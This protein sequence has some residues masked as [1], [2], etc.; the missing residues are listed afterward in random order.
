MCDF[1]LSRK[2]TRPLLGIEDCE[3]LQLIQRVQHPKVHIHTTVLEFLPRTK[4]EFLKRHIDVFT[5]VGTFKTTVKINTDPRVPNIMSPPRRYNFYIIE[6]LKGK[7][8][9]LEKN[10]VITKVTDEIPKF[11]SNLVIREKGNG[12]LR[13]CLDPEYLN[14]AIVRQ[15]YSIPSLDELAYKVKDKKVFTVLDLKDGF[16]HVP[17]DHDSSLLCAFSTPY[18]VYRFKKLPFGAFQQLKNSICQAPALRPYDSTKPMI[19]QADASQT[20]LGACLLQEGTLVSAV[21][22]KLTETEQ[23]YAQI[24]KEMLALW[25][26]AS[27][28][29][30][31][32]YGMRHVTFHTDHQP[33]VSICKK[34]LYQIT[35]NR[36]KRLRLKMLKF[37][38]QVQY[39]PGKY[40]Y[41]ADLLSRQYITDS[42]SDDPDMAEVV[43]EVTRHISIS[44]AVL[45]E[46]RAET[47]KDQGLQ[48]VI[49]Y[50][51]NGWPLHKRKA[52]PSSLQYWKV[53]KDLFTEQG[54]VV[55]DNKIIIPDN[56]RGKVLQQL[57]AAHLGSDKTK[58]R[59]RQIVYWPGI[60]ADI[61]R[62]TQGCRACERNSPNNMKE[63]LIPHEVPTLRYQKV[64]CDLLDHHNKMYLVVVDNFSKW[65]ELKELNNKSSKAVIGALREIFATHGI[66]EEIFGDNNPLNSYECKE[67]A[68][69]MGSTIVTSSPEYPRSNGLAERGVRTAK[70]IL[71]KSADSKSHYLDMVRDYNN[72][73]LCGTPFSPAQLLMSRMCR[74][75]VPT[76]RKSLE[77]KVIDPLPL[78]KRRQLLAKKYHD[79]RARRQP[80]TFT[81]GDKI[82]YRRGGKWH[83]GTIVHKHRTPRSYIIR[84]MR[85]RDLRRNTFHLKRSATATDHIDRQETLNYNIP[86]P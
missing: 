31:F 54:L 78:L 53:Q 42:V 51:K 63:P 24:E 65:L 5:G 69:S 1:L 46:C 15:K 2:H 82:A 22:R 30:K 34:P 72:T 61:E 48:S 41:L 60:T 19:V 20:G 40:M 47:A 29:E 70:Q 44:N 38:P 67:F 37:Q 66:P 43:H 32:I 8:E 68:E 55:L 57:H 10:G 81:E 62:I 28:F 3:K 27:K 6:R 36:L 21:S 25:F 13:I 77:P 49:E 85:G 35:N 84:Q 52:N 80:V 9:A 23:N 86:V 59:A 4:E 12:D 83:K 7:L 11:I 18:G 79:R 76:L 16:W 75:T 73:P 45:E 26:A 56:M 74:T 33:L 39:I 50:Y 17:L 71:S 58:A 14:K 64:S